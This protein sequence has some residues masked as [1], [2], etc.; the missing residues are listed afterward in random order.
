[1]RLFFARSVAVCAIGQTQS[2]SWA[3][4]HQE[5]QRPACGGKGV[6]AGC[7]STNLLLYLSQPMQLALA[8][9][10]EVSQIQSVIKSA[11]Y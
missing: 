9:P 6:S 4:F 5:R 2:G 10:L 7:V 1:M 3:A 11:D 8:G